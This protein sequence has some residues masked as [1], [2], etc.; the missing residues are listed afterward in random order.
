MKRVA[1]IVLIV[2]STI[3]LFAQFDKGD[4]II[5]A[6]GNYIKTDT[7]NGVTTN[8]N[9]TKGQYLNL[10]T[11]IGTFITNKLIVGVGL[12]CNRGNETRTSLL[13]FNDFTQE[14]MMTVKSNVILPG[15]FLGYYQRIVDKLYFSSML[16]FSY[17]KVKSEY[18]TIYAGMSSPMESTEYLNTFKSYSRGSAR[19]SESDYFGTEV[20]PELTYFISS[21]LGL[22][23]GLGAV[24]Y[25]MTDWKTENSNWLV[26]FNPN[27]WKLGIKIKI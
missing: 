27:Y 18:S 9:S 6:D 1:L 15:L 19:S 26:N 10:G 16:R 5:S 3:D 11:S 22:C 2:F 4:I 24:K 25:S 21:K 12:D 7:E 13:Y 8:Q 17:G 23:I 14:E 20:C